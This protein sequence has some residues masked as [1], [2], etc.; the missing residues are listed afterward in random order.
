MFDFIRKPLL[1][2]AWDR[3]LDKEIGKATNF[4]LK[5]AQDLAVYSLLRGT[6]GKRIA[7]IG[8]GSSRLLQ[9]LA[10]ENQCFNVERFEGKDGGPS[11]EI[12]I[13]GVTNIKVFLGE[14][15]PLLEDQSFD[16]VFSVSVVEHVSN[17]E[18]LSFFDDGMRVLKPGGLWLHAI[19]AY[20]QDTP[21]RYYAARFDSYR[22]WLADTRLQPLG[23]VFDGPFIFACDMATNPDN[24]MYS[25]GKIAP[26][27][28]TMRQGAQSV[29]LLVGGRRK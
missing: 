20:I 5:S 29:S 14:F 6:T 7:E 17:D 15:S 12:N 22:H 28:N 23:A 16:V 4:H 24:V 8:G 27:L 26:A 2:D 10:A 21:D 25:W 1:W 11:Q 9:R 18:L 3:G 13:S 19:D